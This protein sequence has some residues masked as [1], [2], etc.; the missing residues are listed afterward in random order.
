[1]SKIKNCGLDQYGAGPF[2][3]HQFRTA[4][5]ERVNVNTHHIMNYQFTKCQ[6]IWFSNKAYTALWTALLLL[7]WYYHTQCPHSHSTTMWKL[8]ITAV[9]LLFP[10]LLP[11]SAVITMVTRDGLIQENQI[12]SFDSIGFTGTVLYLLCCSQ[13][14]HWVQTVKMWSV[15]F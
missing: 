10:N 15:L 12:D 13:P 1:M 14:T 4:G 7:L 8:P 11:I 3:Q 9:I 6:S 5:T 2:E